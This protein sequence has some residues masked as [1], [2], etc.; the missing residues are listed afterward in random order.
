[1]MRIYFPNPPESAGDQNKKKKK[2]NKFFEDVVQPAG[3]N[4]DTMN[5]THGVALFEGAKQKLGS[6]R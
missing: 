1:M 2:D 6:A 3:S 5:V 4:F